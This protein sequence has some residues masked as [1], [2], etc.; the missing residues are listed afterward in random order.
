MLISNEEV[1]P[2]LLRGCPEF[3]G[4]LRELAARYGDRAKDEYMKATLIAHYLWHLY[5]TGS[6]ELLPRFFDFMERL[7]EHGDKD[8]Q[9]LAVVGYLAVMQKASSHNRYP[10]AFA[11]WI[12]PKTKYWWDQIDAWRKAGKNPLHFPYDEITGDK[13]L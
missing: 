10:D 6:R 8:V 9:R 4:E 12:L 11:P 5:G 2:E 13:K 1:I 3:Q 7:V